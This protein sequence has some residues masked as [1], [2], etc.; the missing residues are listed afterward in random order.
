[1]KP[2]VTIYGDGE[3]P[4]LVTDL[5]DIGRFV[6]RIIADDRT[7]NKFVFTWGEVLTQKQIFTAIEA[8]SGE[9]IEREHVSSE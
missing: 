2:N 5:R 1:M 4:N 6:A 3:A 8:A 9:K 7:L